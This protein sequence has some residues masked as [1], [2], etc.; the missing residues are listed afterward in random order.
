MCET[1]VISLF[2]LD[3]FPFSVYLDLFMRNCL[4]LAS[5]VPLL[6]TPASIIGTEVLP[7]ASLSATHLVSFRSLSASY[8]SSREVRSAFS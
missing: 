3:L 4:L 8:I 7:N 6:S 1:L 2:S 5:L